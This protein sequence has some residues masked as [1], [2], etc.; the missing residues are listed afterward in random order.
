MET[1][2]QKDHPRENGEAEEYTV[3]QLDDLPDK[4]SSDWGFKTEPLGQ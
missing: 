2:L 3:I 4:Y 1:F